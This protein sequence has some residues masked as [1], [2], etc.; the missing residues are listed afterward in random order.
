[1]IERYAVRT[2]LEVSTSHGDATI[3]LGEVAFSRASFQEIVRYV[4]RGGYPKWRN[5]QPPAY[6]SAMREAVE[7]SEHWLFAG[8]AFDS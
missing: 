7:K 2:A 4:W 1:M 6:V 3:V 8:I 5:G